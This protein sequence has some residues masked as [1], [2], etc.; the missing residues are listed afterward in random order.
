MADISRHSLKMATFENVCL[1]FTYTV[2][3]PFRGINIEPYEPTTPSPG[4][5][6][7]RGNP[8]AMSPPGALKGLATIKKLKIAKATVLN[9]G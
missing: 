6:Q 2:L 8:D 9:I 3:T 5:F 7:A 4:Q 1:Q